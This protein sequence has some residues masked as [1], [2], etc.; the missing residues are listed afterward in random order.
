MKL[1]MEPGKREN[2]TSYIEYLSFSLP[3]LLLD[4]SQ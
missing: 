2:D 1:I 4:H 3:S